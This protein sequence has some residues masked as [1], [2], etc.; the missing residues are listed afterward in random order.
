MARGPKLLLRSCS[1]IPRSREWLL[2][3]TLAVC[4]GSFVGCASFQPAAPPKPQL[5]TTYYR[6][7]TS[8]SSPPPQASPDKDG[9]GASRATGGRATA[10]CIAHAGRA[11]S[12][13]STARTVPARCKFIHR[14]T[15]A[16]D[17]TRAEFRYRAELVDPRGWGARISRPVNSYRQGLVTRR[18]G[19][20]L[21]PSRCRGVATLLL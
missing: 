6:K 12:R 3:G 14:T 1:V 18:D 17:T 19:R 20:R 15:A 11:V 5:M 16:V 21:R 2:A 9:V 13:G 8:T 10:A 4:V 7:N